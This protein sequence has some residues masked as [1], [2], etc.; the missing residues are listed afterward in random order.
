LCVRD[1]PHRAAGPAVE[2]PSGERYFFWHG[3]EVPS[4]II[5]T[6]QAITREQVA[7]E[8]NLSLRH[9]MMERFGMERFTIIERWQEWRTCHS[10]K[11]F[12]PFVASGLHHVFRAISERITAHAQGTVQTLMPGGVARP[13]D[14]TSAVAAMLRF[15]D[16]WGEAARPICW[17]VDRTSALAYIRARGGGLPRAAYW[18]RLRIARALDA[19]WLKGLWT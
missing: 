15:L 18:P 16:E 1:L 9:C 10:P 14:K 7:G 8:R 5:E 13:R 3:I 6:P 4:W 17:F 12:A 19:V 2:W 11:E